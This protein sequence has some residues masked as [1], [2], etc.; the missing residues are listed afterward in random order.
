VRDEVA[1]LLADD[2]RRTAMA[3]A[4]RRLAQPDAA[5]VIAEELIA[6]ARAAR[7]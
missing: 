5:N 3:T 1:A 6:L 2:E 7:R 4:M